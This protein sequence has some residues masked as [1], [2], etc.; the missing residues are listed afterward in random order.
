MPGLNYKAAT[1]WENKFRSPTGAELLHGL[2]KP[3]AALVDEARTRLLGV[4][5]A[6]EEIVWH[7][8]PWR[9]T[10]SYRGEGALSRPWAYLVPE[11]AKPRLVLPL[12]LEELSRFPL[13]KLTKPARDP[14]SHG[15]EVDGVH[16]VEWEI[17]VRA[18]MDE[19]LTLAVARLQAAAH[20]RG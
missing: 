6:R 7:G 11:P 1:I 18:L 9:W 12:T 2:A 5:G 20:A 4:S 19:V 14:L 15:V 16:W 13:R 10:F 3:H 17:S 8:L